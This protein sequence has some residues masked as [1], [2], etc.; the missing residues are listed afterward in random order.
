MVKHEDENGNTLAKTE[1]TTKK[2]FDKYTTS[3]KQITGYKL[4]ET[5]ENATGT[6]T[7]EKITVTYV[8]QP[9]SAKVEVVKKDNDTG[10]IITKEDT[11]FALYEWQASTNTWVAPTHINTATVN[12]TVS[13][14]MGAILKEKTSGTKGT[15]T[16]SMYYDTRNQGKFKIVEYTRPWG[17][18]TTNWVREIQITDN[19]IFSSEV[20][21]TQVRG[22]INFKKN[23][24]QVNYNNS[25]YGE[26]Y[27]Q[28][29]ATL[30]GASYGVYAKENIIS[31]DDGAVVY[32][33]G[34]QVMTG[35]TDANGK[36]TWSNLPLGKYYVQEITASDGY[37]KDTKPHEVDLKTYYSNNYY[38]KGN[39]TTANVIYQ[40]TT[41]DAQYAN[42]EK[43]VI[44]KETV[45]KQKF[46]LTKLSLSEDSTIANPL[47][48][49]GFKI[50]RIKDLSAVKDGKIKPN[51]NG[52]YNA[53][54]FKTIDFTKEQ[55]A[56]DFSSNTNGVRIP[57]LFTN[58][59]GTVTS[60]ELAYGKYVVIE[61]TVP[62]GMQ[63]IQP[64]IVDIYEDSRNPKNMIYPID[65]EFEARIRVI[66]K[67]ATTGMPVLKASAAYRIW[68]ITQNEYV[69]QWVTYPNKV[70]YGTESNPY[71]TTEEGYLLTPERLGMGEYELREVEAPEGYVIAGKE[72]NPK[73][74]VRFSIN[75]N[76]VYEM[77][78]DLGAQNAIINVEQENMPQL[79]T[80]TVSKSGEFLSS[81]QE[82]E[83]QYQFGYKQR[84]VTDAKFA[85]YAKEDIYTQDNQTDE[86]GE[87]TTIYVKD[88][89]I[90]EVET[91]AEGKAIFERLPLG[92]YIVV[93]TKAGE[94]FTLNTER[95]EVSFTYEGQEKAVIDRDIEYVNERQKVSINIHKL[96]EDTGESISGAEFGL[97][98]KETI[99]YRDNSGTTQ[100]IPADKLVLK[101]TSGEDGI[102]SFQDENLPLGKYYVKELQAPRGYVTSLEIMD[103]NCSYAGQE[104]DTMVKELEFSNT[105]TKIKIR[106]TDYETGANLT[107]TQVVIRDENGN[108]LGTYTTDENGEI[109]VKG[110]EVGKKYSIG[111]IKARTGYVKDLL[112]TNDTEDEN[113]LIKSKGSNGFVIFKVKD[114]EELQIVTVSN[115]AKVAQLEI[116]KTGDVLIGNEYETQ[117]IDTARLEVYTKEDIV[118]PDGKQGVIL[119]KG[120]KI[121]EGQ[122]QDGIITI[123]KLPEELIKTQT[124]VI[125]LLLERGLPLGEYEIKEIEAPKGYEL[126]EQPKSVSLQSSDDNQEI[127]KITVEF[128]NKRIG[129]PEDPPENPPEN[130]PEDNPPEDNPPENNPPGDNPGSGDTPGD[131]SGD[132]NNVNSGSNNKDG[133]NASNSANK[134]NSESKSA[135]MATKSLPKTGTEILPIIIPIVSILALVLIEMKRMK[136]RKS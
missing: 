12:G 124:E 79:G 91:N 11:V 88:E 14:G 29:D 101:A 89:F 108:D 70:Q 85:I 59:D 126:E 2:F 42:S 129:T 6:M 7:E 19:Q 107:N 114:S 87:R 94:G 24:A 98:T 43:R 47:Q 31:P 93:E 38:N 15:Y 18:T 99:T 80:I 9:Y 28:G 36:I 83:S 81:S 115:K 74:N 77:D 48:G 102:A 22:T 130:P 3:A 49:A 10:N 128:Y 37:L 68:N 136:R 111:E 69:E 106:V 71:R 116:Q 125:Q 73:P 34:Q 78:P 109:K 117:K 54:D 1:T 41:T 113:E 5:P 63:A 40:N 23:D 62:E 66:K 33:T 75:T 67:D 39:Q 20:K 32:R 133:N 50:Y 76:I 53:V 120:T 27:A 64:F 96:D 44:S 92:E 61:S 51:A 57:E 90:S 72:E 8:Y 134:A 127:E 35:T 17:Y 55:T 105:M 135:N 84:P 118:H 26:N 16:A 86:N 122:T 121:A 52:S 97:Y 46:Q 131:N 65:R 45:K 56:L 30:Q 58:E 95:K 132:R 104:V 25:S 123:E 110:F 82:Q 60:P 4:K 100:T 112:F 103:V 13:D 21:N 119:P